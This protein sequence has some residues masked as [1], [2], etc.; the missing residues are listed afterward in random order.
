MEIVRGLII[1]V[2]FKVE[3]L[4][5]INRIEI[6]QFVKVFFSGTFESG[7]QMMLDFEYDD[8]VFNK[9]ENSAVFLDPGQK[10]HISYYTVEEEKALRANEQYGIS[11]DGT[12]GVILLKDCP[13]NVNE[14]NFGYK[15]VL[16]TSYFSVIY[17]NRQRQVLGCIYWSYNFN[18]TKNKWEPTFIGRPH[19]SRLNNF[20]ATAKRVLKNNNL[21]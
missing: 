17:K 20:S 6:T 3:G 4:K 12:A 9:N 13:S 14:Q 15:H 10:G 11:T 2:L 21:L 1:Y 19:F 8:A 16:F 18:F 5:E 7:R